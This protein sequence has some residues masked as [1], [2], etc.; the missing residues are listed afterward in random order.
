MLRAWILSNR[1]G[2]ENLGSGLSR[3]FFAARR[4]SEDL[5]ANSN[6]GRSLDDHSCADTLAKVGPLAR[7]LTRNGTLNVP[8][9]LYSS[10]SEW[11]IRKS[12]RYLGSSHDFTQGAAALS[13]ACMNALSSLAE[14]RV[15]A[16]NV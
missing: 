11:G 3:A 6:N 8:W 9:C 1:V 5:G 16:R 4:L 7:S 14:N 15:R 12:A 13:K 10:F 2:N